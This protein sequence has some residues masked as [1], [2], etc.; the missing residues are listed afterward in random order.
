MLCCAQADERPPPRWRPSAL[1][2]G[3][4]VT[5]GGGGD[6]LLYVPPL[7][8]AGGNGL[9]AFIVAQH[10]H[11]PEDLTPCGA[12]PVAHAAQRIAEQGPA[13]AHSRA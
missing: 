5:F 13:V 12:R 6:G 1:G 9:H 8:L 7:A 10:D 2:G 4:A 3:P 11:N